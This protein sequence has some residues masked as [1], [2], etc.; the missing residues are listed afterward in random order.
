MHQGQDRD[1]PHIGKR[2]PKLGRRLV[3]CQ[4]T[5]EGRLQAL[6]RLLHQWL[7]F[8]II[9]RVALPYPGQLPAPAVGRLN[10]YLVIDQAGQRAPIGPH[11][12]RPPLQDAG[13]DLPWVEGPGDVERH[14][15]QLAAV[16]LG[17]PL[18][19]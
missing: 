11:R 15:D 5:A 7:P 16:L 18:E 9:E 1:L 13:D 3:Q 6:D 17:L 10:Y 2:L 12:V 19:G 14:L 4:A 8:E